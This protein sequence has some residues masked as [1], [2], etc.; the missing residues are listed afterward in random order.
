MPALLTLPV[1]CAALACGVVDQ[2]VGAEYS[3]E[4]ETAGMPTP[5]KLV[6]FD[7]GFDF[8]TMSRRYRIWRKAV[9]FDMKVDAQGHATECEVVDQFRRT[10]INMRLCEV[11]MDHS[12]FEP[13]R[14]AENQPIEGSYRATISYADL[15]AEFD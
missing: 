14:D 8:L 15:R 3:R 4:L 5:A 2:G 11:A 7:G 9:Q 13:A 6:S 1:A 10:L 12:T